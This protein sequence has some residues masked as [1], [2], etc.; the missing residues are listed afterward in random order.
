M[1]FLEEKFQN[2]S[3]GTLADLTTARFNKMHEWLDT[4]EDG[5]LSEFYSKRQQI[6]RQNI[7]TATIQEEFRLEAARRM[8]NEV[9]T[10]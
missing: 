2:L 9:R 6:R 5:Q 1:K 7:E 8:L 10:N 3:F 4:M